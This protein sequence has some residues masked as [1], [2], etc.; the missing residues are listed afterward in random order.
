MHCMCIP[1]VFVLSD[2]QLIL[3]HVHQIKRLRDEAM[4]SKQYNSTTQCHRYMLCS[5]SNKTM[6]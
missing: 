1:A 5:N 3:G 2:M 4:K 6:F